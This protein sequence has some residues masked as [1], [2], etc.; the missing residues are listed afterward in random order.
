MALVD[1]RVTR[2]RVLSWCMWDWATQPFATVITTFVFG[3]YIA[4]GSLFGSGEHDDTPAAMLGV[5]TA[6]AGVLIALLA[7]V[8]GQ[9]TDRSGRRM[10]HLAWQTGLLAALSAALWFV[11]PTPSH[12][13]LGLVLLGLG[14]IVAEVANVNYY[15]SIERVATPETVGR[16]SG[17]G[18]GMGYLGG[19][20]IL[21]IIVATSGG[22]VDPTDVRTA[23]LLCGAWTV[24]FS[25]PIFVAIKDRPV[26]SP[27]PRR[28]VV[29]AYRDLFASIRRIHRV[30][31]HTIWFLLSSALFRD[32]LA[33]VFTFGAVLAVKAFGFSPTE[34]IVFGVVANV[35]AGL[36]TIAFGYLDDR[37]GPKRVILISLACLVGLGSAVFVLH[38][39][40][41][42]VFWVFGL[43]MTVFVGPAQSASRSFLARIIPEGHSGEVFGLYA[44][45]GRAVSFLSS[46]MWV[47]LLW[48][49][50][51]VVPAGE[52]AVHFGVLGVVLVLAV[53]LVALLPVREDGHRPVEI[54]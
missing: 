30:S 36:A 17:L 43:L 44:T 13:W 6:V 41:A 33:G 14:N 29:A 32:G 54:S 52:S 24:V 1:R 45:T 34:V 51:M 53:G 12:L 5:A 48:I 47:L 21:L 16:V 31:P 3:A 28:G 37:I 19:I 2:G 27:K 8:L 4:S 50:S 42:W 25:I 49:G 38:S 39:A 18:W 11:A 9:D 10:R 46:T 23:M 15:A 26:A 40:G 35:T 7:P 20:L 22:D